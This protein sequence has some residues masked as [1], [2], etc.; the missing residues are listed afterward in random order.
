MTTPLIRKRASASRPSVEWDDDDFDVLEDGV[1]V[2]RILRRWSLQRMRRGFGVSL[3]ATIAT[4]HQS[5]GRRRVRRRWRRSL[6]D[7]DSNMGPC[8]S[9]IYF[10]R[11]LLSYS[12]WR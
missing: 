8:V 5:I 10:C 12:R 2:G 3:T 9:L 11:C 4:A 6:R 7:G 1:V